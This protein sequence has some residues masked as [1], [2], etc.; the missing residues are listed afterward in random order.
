MPKPTDNEL[1]DVVR[2]GLQMGVSLAHEVRCPAQQ[3]RIIVANDAL[4][5]LHQ[6]QEQYSGE[7]VWTWHRDTGHWA[8]TCGY[9]YTVDVLYAH[10]RTRRRYC[11]FC[12][13]P[14]REATDE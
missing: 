4:S 9:N 12:G 6:L 8:T 10:P 13:K 11:C 7:C 14:I 3:R 5:A 1:W 2:R